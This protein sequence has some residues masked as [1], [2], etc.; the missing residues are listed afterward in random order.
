MGGRLGGFGGG[1]GAVDEDLIG[2][3]ERLQVG[4]G[5]GGESGGEQFVEP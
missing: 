4:A 5:Y 1:R 3:E 2:G